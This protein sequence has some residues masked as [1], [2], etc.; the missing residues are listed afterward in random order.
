MNANWF[1]NERKQWERIEA[2]ATEAERFLDRVAALRAKASNSQALR[3]LIDVCL[4]GSVAIGS[5]RN[6]VGDNAARHIERAVNRDVLKRRSAADGGDVA[7][8]IA[9]HVAGD[10]TR[11]VTRDVASQAASDAAVGVDGREVTSGT[12]DVADSDAVER[13]ARRTDRIA[14]RSRA[15]DGDV[16]ER[17]SRRCRAANRRVVDRAARNRGVA[18]YST[19]CGNRTSDGQSSAECGVS[20]YPQRAANGRVAGDSQSARQ[21]RVA[22]DAERTANSGVA[23]RCKRTARRN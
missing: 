4:V 7:R 3:H 20:R 11:H 10:V 9:R 22:R 18:S 8:H 6:E 5:R 1:E 13:A 14:Q 15:V 21:R 12:I 2:A 19:I 17:A 23:L 16:G